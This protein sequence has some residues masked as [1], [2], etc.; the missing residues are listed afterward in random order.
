LLRAGRRPS[1]AAPTRLKIN[2]LFKE[3]AMSSHI[4][5]GDESEGEPTQSRAHDLQGN[6]PRENGGGRSD[7]Q[8][9]PGNPP[10]PAVDRGGGNGGDHVRSAGA[11]LPPGRENATGT[12][13]NPPTPPTDRGGPPDGSAPQAARSVR[14]R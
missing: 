9:T 8:P 6:A 7:A 2:G 4:R 14:H 13:G 1:A 3:G 11:E 12:G 5:E 10:T